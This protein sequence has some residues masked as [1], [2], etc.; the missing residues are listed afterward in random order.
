MLIPFGITRTDAVG[1]ILLLQAPVAGGWGAAGF[2][3][4]RRANIK[5]DA[6]R[7]DPA[8]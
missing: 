3:K 5:V 7:N 6:A 4:F 8:A 1:Y 2:W